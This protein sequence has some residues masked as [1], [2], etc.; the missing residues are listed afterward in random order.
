MLCFFSVLLIC[1]IF[2]T[3]IDHSFDEG[4]GPEDA[5][6]PGYLADQGKHPFDHVWENIICCMLVE[7]LFPLHM[8][9]NTSGGSDMWSLS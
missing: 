6:D 9:I 8:I 5:K 2:I 4:V 3:T 7:Q 1:I